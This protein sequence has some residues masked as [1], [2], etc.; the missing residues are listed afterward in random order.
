MLET[1]MIFGENFRFLIL[2][3][4]ILF[5]IQFCKCPVSNKILPHMMKKSETNVIWVVAV[6]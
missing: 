6:N 3:I 2:L 5:K 4:K 1:D